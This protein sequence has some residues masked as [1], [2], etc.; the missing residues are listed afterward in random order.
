LF[1]TTAKYWLAATDPARKDSSVMTYKNRTDAY[2]YDTIAGGYCN[3]VFRQ[4]KIKVVAGLRADYFRLHHEFGV[5]PRCAFSY[6]MS[7]AGTVTLGGGLYYQQSAELVDIYG[8]IRSFGIPDPESPQKV[9]TLSDVKLQRSWQGV[10]SWEKKFEDSHSLTVETYYKWY[11][12]EYPMANPDLFQ[13]EVDLLQAQKED[14]FW[15]I[16][17]PRGRKKAYGL[18]L[19]FQRHQEHKFSYAVGYSLFS[20]QQKYADLSWYNDPN[21]VRNNVIVTLGYELFKRNTISIRALANEGRRYCKG[22]VDQYGLMYYDT[23]TSYFTER[24]DPMVSVSLRYNFGFL[25]R[26]GT[27]AGYVEL[28]NVLNYSPVIERK[29][30]WWGYWDHKDNGIVPLV[31]LTADF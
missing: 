8:K 15:R 12:R 9:P 2:L 24:L 19:F 20:V 17:A 13:F 23:S 22:M 31:G 7:R 1:Q 29:I 25:S 27:I 5:S 16:N 3:Y 21:N 10:L 30:V 4:D 6:G 11:D 14:Q 18:E 28:W 26:F